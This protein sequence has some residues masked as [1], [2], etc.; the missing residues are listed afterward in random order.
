MARYRNLTGKSG[1]L[2]YQT[3][4]DSITLTFANGDRYLYGPTRPGRALVDRMKAL[5]KSGRGLSTFVSQHVGDAYERKFPA[6][7]RAP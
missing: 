4:A 3:T 5:A 6:G 1:V 2:A 7:S